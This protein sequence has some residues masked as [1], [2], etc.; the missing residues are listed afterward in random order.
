[1]IDRALDNALADNRSYGNLDV[2]H[3]LFRRL[4]AEDPVHWTCL[5]YTS[6]CV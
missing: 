4:R 1:M 2:Q 6:R 3:A 5:L